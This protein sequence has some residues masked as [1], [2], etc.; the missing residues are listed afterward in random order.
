MAFFLMDEPREEYEEAI[1]VPPSG[2]MPDGVLADHS[3][4]G[5]S[6][7]IGYRATS[8][9]RPMGADRCGYLPTMCRASRSFSAQINS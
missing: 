4:S 7:K 6:D 1:Y 2:S 8:D 5:A 9:S 3:M